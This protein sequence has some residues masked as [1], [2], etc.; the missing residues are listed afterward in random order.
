MILRKFRQV[1]SIAGLMPLFRLA[2]DHGYAFP[3][4]TAA[5]AL[6]EQQ[7]VTK[8]RRSVSCGFRLTTMWP[9][10]ELAGQELKEGIRSSSNAYSESR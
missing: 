6:R 8:H 7:V 2:G 1:T 3:M 9:T 10:P 4:A 5:A